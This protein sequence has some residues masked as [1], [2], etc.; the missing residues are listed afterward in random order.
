MNSIKTAIIIGTSNINSP[1]M[2]TW[3]SWPPNIFFLEASSFAHFSK[4]DCKYIF[5]LSFIYLNCSRMFHRAKPWLLSRYDLNADFQRLHRFFLF[6]CWIFL[7]FFDCGLAVQQKDVLNVAMA[8]K[9]CHKATD[10]KD[11]H[12]LHISQPK[13]RTSPQID[14]CSRCPSLFLITLSV[15]RDLGEHAISQPTAYGS[16]VAVPGPFSN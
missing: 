6:F 14:C 8:A 11:L 3:A 4:C 9:L 12:I 7:F 15:R 5:F 1:Q 2:R 13:S 16:S 10:K